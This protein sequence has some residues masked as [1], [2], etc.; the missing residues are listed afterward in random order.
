MALGHTTMKVDKY[1]DPYEDLEKQVLKDLEYAATRL[2]GTMQKISKR[3]HTGRSSKIIQIEYNV[4][5][6]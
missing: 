6:S 2:G 4:D 1:Y 3:D 5:M